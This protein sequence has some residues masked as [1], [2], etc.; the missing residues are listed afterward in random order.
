ML[1][2]IQRAAILEMHAQKQSSRTIARVEGE[3][4][5]CTRGVAAEHD[6][7]S[8]AGARGDLRAYRQQIIELLPRCKNNL[9]RVQEELEAIGAT[10][11]Y[12]A[13]TAF[14]RR[15]GIGQEPIVASGR[16]PASS[17]IELQHDTSP[18]KVELAGKFY[19]AQ[20]ASAVLCYSRMLFFQIYPTFNGFDCKVF[21]TEALRYIGA[22]QAR[23]DRQQPTLCPAQAPVARWCQCRRWRLLPERYGFQF[24]AHELATPT[25]RRMSSGSSITSRTTSWPAAASPGGRR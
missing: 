18:H 20:T 15:H 12:S 9:V 8:C 11:S 6:G 16:Y 13:L 4:L 23:R 21:L 19:K 1:S 10:L 7:G 22:F 17:G 14:C 3:P 25:G 24:A 5:V 2:Q